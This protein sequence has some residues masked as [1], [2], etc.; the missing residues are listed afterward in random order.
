MTETVDQ[1]QA[2]PPRALASIIEDATSLS[3]FDGA[4]ATPPLTL[5]SPARPSA[6]IGRTGQSEACPGS[7]RVTYGPGFDLI[8][9]PS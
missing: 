1:A 2:Q 4:K 5:T 8:Q 3:F 7:S 9:T 6:S